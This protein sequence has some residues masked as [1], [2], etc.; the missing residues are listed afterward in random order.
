RPRRTAASRAASRPSRPPCRAL[1]DRTGRLAPLRSPDRDPLE[2][3]AVV[4]RDRAPVPLGDE[5]RGARG[6][7]GQPPA[8]RDEARPLPE[9]ARDVGVGERLGEALGVEED[10][11]EV[12]VRQLR[13][14]QQRRTL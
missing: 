8:L 4:Q 10:R 5:E 13:A 12:L 7:L 11:S 14:T 9:D 3:A 1:P 2:N 6:A